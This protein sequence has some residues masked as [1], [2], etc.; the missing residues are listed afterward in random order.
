MDKNKVLKKINSTKNLEELRL[1]MN[2]LNEDLIEN[3]KIREELSK[4][5][6]EVKEDKSKIFDKEREIKVI[7]NFIKNYIPNENK[8][9]KM[10][11][12]NGDIKI[13]FKDL[14]KNISISLMD[15]SKYFQHLG[16]EKMNKNKK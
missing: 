1:I 4:K 15:F 12:L 10:K 13:E 2:F 14:L 7:K 6:F 11:T 3:L 8:K 5:I 16:L 9:I